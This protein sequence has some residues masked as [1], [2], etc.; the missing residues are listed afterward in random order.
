MSIR[1][2]K[3]RWFDDLAIALVVSWGRGR[4]GREPQLAQGLSWAP[5][6]PPFRS[7]LSGRAAKIRKTRTGPEEEC[8]LTSP[9]FALFF[10]RPTAAL[11]RRVSWGQLG[12]GLVTRKGTRLQAIYGCFLWSGWLRRCMGALC[13]LFPGGHVKSKTKKLGADAL[14]VA[15]HWPCGP[16]V[17][18]FLCLAYHSDRFLVG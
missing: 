10:R 2:C 17:P 14:L 8:R 11:W 7:H 9:W 12:S 4:R 5:G 3:G 1:S 6:I 15:I 18:R 13:C 16:K